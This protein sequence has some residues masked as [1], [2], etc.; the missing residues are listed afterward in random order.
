M[1]LIESK[2]YLIR[3]QCVESFWRD[4]STL[5]SKYAYANYNIEDLGSGADIATSSSKPAIPATRCVV[6]YGVQIAEQMDS[7]RSIYSCRGAACGRCHVGGDAAGGSRRAYSH[8]FG[9]EGDLRNGRRK[10]HSVQ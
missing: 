2:S 10:R 1:Y 9:G 7:R 8:P 6:R 3:A 5:S 4:V